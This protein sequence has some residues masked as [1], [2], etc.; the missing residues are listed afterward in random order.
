LTAQPFGQPG[1]EFARPLSGIAIGEFQ[2]QHIDHGAHIALALDKVGKG[3]TILPAVPKLLRID[4]DWIIG[5]ACPVQSQENFSAPRIG[6]V[7]FA[8]QDL[9][10]PFAGNRQ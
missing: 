9:L 8:P 2:Q 1:G 7:E 3:N 4:R 6:G 5:R 10:D